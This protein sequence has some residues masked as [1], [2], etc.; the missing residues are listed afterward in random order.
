[1]SLNERLNAT[2]KELEAM[3]REL[4]THLETFKDRRRGD[5]IRMLHEV[6]S[7]L[8]PLNAYASQAGQDRVIDR[9]F[10]GKRDGT[11][12]DVGGYDGVTGS[13]TLFFERIRGWTG[14]LVEPVDM[15]RT[16]AEQLRSCPCLPF[17]VSSQNGEA[18]FMAVTRGYT[19][20]S[21]LIEDY[22]PNL[23]EQVRDDSRHVEE[24]INVKTRTLQSLLEDH[25]LPNPDFVSLDIE[26]GEVSAL[27]AFPFDR[28]RVGAWAIENNSAS[29]NIGDIMRKN[30]YKLIEYCGPDEIYAHKSV[31]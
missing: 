17:A 22:D 16:K 9:L 28:H 7:M 30:D 4:T 31:L 14:I 21:G 13:N 5:V 10:G 1:M 8:D 15:F 3:R 24:E 26:G 25:D 11:F 23:L 18:R 2:R 29:G 20:M 27:E 6:R 19:Q 12:I